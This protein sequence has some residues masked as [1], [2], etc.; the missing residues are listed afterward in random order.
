MHSNP[1]RRTGKEVSAPKEARSNEGGEFFYNHGHLQSH[2]LPAARAAQGH[3][4]ESDQTGLDG[5]LPMVLN[6]AG[7]SL[8]V[9]IVH[10]LPSIRMTG[11]NRVR[12]QRLGG[13]VETL[14]LPWIIVG[15]FNMEP[16]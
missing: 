6:F 12:F 1:A 10:A 5:L 8:V 15:D 3:L 9:I 14:S 4:R 7:Y 13:L 16:D 2:Y 11:H